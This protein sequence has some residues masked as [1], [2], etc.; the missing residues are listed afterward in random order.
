MFF[1]SKDFQ[2][3]EGSVLLLVLIF[4]DVV[5]LLQSVWADAASAAA[6]LN[7]NKLKRNHSGF[8]CKNGTETNSLATTQTL[9]DLPKDGRRA[10]STKSRAT[11][12]TLIGIIATAKDRGRALRTRCFSSWPP[13]AGRRDGF[14]GRRG[15]EGAKSSPWPQTPFS[16]PP[17]LTWHQTAAFRALRE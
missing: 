3:K 10:E 13:P 14:D 5:F 9:S 17:R 6:S 15:G 12:A 7:E 2:W 4:P 11:K 16:A 1:A 8:R